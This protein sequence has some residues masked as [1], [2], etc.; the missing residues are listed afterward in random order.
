MT[1]FLYGLTMTLLIGTGSTSSSAPSTDRKLHVL[2]SPRSPPRRQKTNINGKSTDDSA[3]SSSITSDSAKEGHFISPYMPLN[4]EVIGDGASEF[5]Q[6]SLMDNF[7]LLN[8]SEEFS[9]M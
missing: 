4:G 6:F 9:I 1:S 5:S 8:G 7:S 3:P 2:L